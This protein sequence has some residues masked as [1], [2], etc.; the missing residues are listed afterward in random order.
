MLCSLDVLENKMIL[1]L[2]KLLMLWVNRQVSPLK[3]IPQYVSSLGRLGWTAE[4]GKPMDSWQSLCVKGTTQHEA[5]DVEEEEEEKRNNMG[6]KHCKRL[7]TFF[8]F[9]YKDWR[10]LTTEQKLIK[11]LFEYHLFTNKLQEESMTF[12]WLFSELLREFELELPFLGRPQ[13]SMFFFYFIQRARR[14]RTGHLKDKSTA[15]LFLSTSMYNP[16]F[17]LSFTL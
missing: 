3:R 11:N 2:R 5:K 14:G 17:L 1:F 16:L 13:P 4:K 6:I 8:F 12:S 10:L 15:Y 9:L 7:K